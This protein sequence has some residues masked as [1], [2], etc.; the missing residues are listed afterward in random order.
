MPF[1]YAPTDADSSVNATFSVFAR[2]IDTDAIIEDAEGTFRPSLV[3]L[4][5]SGATTPEPSTWVMMA[6]G[7]AGLG[8]MG[9]RGSRTTVA[10]AA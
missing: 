3:T 6:L 8:F 7:F 4:S 1:K 5:V 10:H 9:W 2:N